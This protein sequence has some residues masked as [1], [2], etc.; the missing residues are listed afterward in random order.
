[1]PLEL[2]NIVIDYKNQLEILTNEEID[3][4]INNNLESIQR[5]KEH[6]LELMS[7]KSLFKKCDYIK[8]LDI[9][10]EVDIIIDHVKE[11]IIMN[12]KSLLY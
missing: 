7:M 6:N 1:M 4:I 9:E 12:N 2:E 11:M 10:E 3:T 5:I 8:E